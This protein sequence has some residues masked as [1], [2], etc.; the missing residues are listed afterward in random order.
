[1][2]DMIDRPVFAAAFLSY[3]VL[4]CATPDA[5]VTR[6]VIEQRESPAYKGQSF[7]NAGQV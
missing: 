4:G 5:R 7:G 1:L 2:S 6:V 3:A